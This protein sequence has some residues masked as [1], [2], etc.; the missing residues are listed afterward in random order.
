VTLAEAQDWDYVVVPGWAAGI[1]R[2]L[3]HDRSEFWLGLGDP[4]LFREVY[5]APVDG[6][7][8]VYEVLPQE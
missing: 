8:T 3:G 6:G 5:R 7:T 2:S 1:Y 4:A